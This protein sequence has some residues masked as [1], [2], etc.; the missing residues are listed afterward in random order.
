MRRWRQSRSDY[1]EPERN[2]GTKI[3]PT[4]WLR[5]PTDVGQI[6]LGSSRRSRER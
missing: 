2:V 3:R 1:T 4:S 6:A 5:K